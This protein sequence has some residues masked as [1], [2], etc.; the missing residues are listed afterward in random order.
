MKP[1]PEPVREYLLMAGCIAV[2]VMLR[3][4]A[5]D[6]ESAWGDEALTTTCFPAASFEAYLDC[7][8]AEDS[9][10]RLAPIYYLVQYAW[11]LVAGG[12]LIALR[13]LSVCLYVIAC[14]LLFATAR[15]AGGSRAGLWAATFFSLSLFQ[16]Y[17][18]QEIRFYALMNVFAIAA[19]YGLMR[20]LRT[21]RKGWLALSVA[22][23][24]ALIWTHTFA[25]VYVLAQG[26]FMAF[27]WKPW[28]P[29]VHWFTCH[30][31][32]AAA[33]A[34]WP[35]I[36]GYNFAGQSAAY[37]DMPAGPW[38]LANA[39]VQLAGGRFSNMD[40]A[41]YIA[42]GVS[43]DLVI[44]GAVALLA[45]IGTV[46]GL[47]GRTPHDGAPNHARADAILLLVTFAG[48]ILGLYALGWLWRPC[49]FSRYIVYG[50]MPLYMLAAMGLA[51]IPRGGLRR[52]LAA[53][54]L[55]AFAWQNLALPRP[56][57]PDYAG[58]AR[59]VAAD[60]ASEPIVL[61]LK[62]FNYDAVEIGRAHV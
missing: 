31:A 51:G 35:V 37:N 5:L 58:V 4:L 1:A 62:P 38:E 18:G 59:A 2:G 14:V 9:R 40:P 20:Y 32:L 39:G 17:Y 15:L 16:I 49:F 10:L 29:T 8:F 47:R 42:G 21:P 46:R 19:L 52:G 23:N 44:A 57:R 27:R 13:M 48:S 3:V 25:V 54:V 22:A 56:F 11:S 28:R 61:A 45:L 36:L 34:A 53:M 43:L 50:A 7:V 55:L 30:V 60:P 33:L 24:A 12:S 41:D 26:L 6:Q